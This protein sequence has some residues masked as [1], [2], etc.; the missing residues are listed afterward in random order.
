MKVAE[1]QENLKRWLD[2]TALDVDELVVRRL[3]SAGVITHIGD[4]YQVRYKHL[5]R[6]ERVSVGKWE[7]FLSK[8]HSAKHKISLQQFFYGLNLEGV[9]WEDAEALSREFGSAVAFYTLQHTHTGVALRE[10]LFQALGDVLLTYL[11]A[12]V[13]TH[14]RKKEIH[15]L[16]YNKN[17]IIHRHDDVVTLSNKRVHLHGRF[18]GYT[19][20]DIY[21]K[22]VENGAT[23]KKK[24]TDDFDN[25]D[26]IVVGVRYPGTGKWSDYVPESVRVVSMDMA[27]PE[28]EM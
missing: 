19:H 1:T 27:L 5:E 18:P 13:I 15:S 22:L 12:R 2:A 20:E 24:V 8:I 6:I 23:V 9:S 14:Q 21:N 11:L 26:V 7:T 4:L 16:C 25:V 17:L 3:V 28:L 10:K